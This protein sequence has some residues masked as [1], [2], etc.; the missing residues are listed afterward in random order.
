MTYTH[1][2]NTHCIAMTSITTIAGPTT[3]RRNT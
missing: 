1:M 2:Q 3:A